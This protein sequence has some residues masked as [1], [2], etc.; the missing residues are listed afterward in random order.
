MPSVQ[1]WPLL[2]MDGGSDVTVVE[3]EFAHEQ[4][5]VDRAYGLLERGLADAE[6]N[7]EGHGGVHRAT[8][9]AMKRALDILRESRGTGQLIFGRV[10]D[11]DG[12]RYI[13]RRRVYDED[14]DLVVIG[15]HAPAAQVYYEA[16]AQDP[17]GLLLKRTFVEENRRLQRVIDEFVVRSAGGAAGGGAMTGAGMSDA[18][19]GEL[20]RSRDGA[21]RE[22]V[23]TIQAEQFRIIRADRDCVLVV[24]GGPGTGKTVVGLHRAAWL[25]FNHQQLRRQGILVV[26]PSSALLSYIAGVLPSL[27]ASDVSQTDLTSLYAGEARPV[28]ADDVETARVKG[29]AQ[30]AQMLRRALDARTGWTGADLELSLG[31]ARIRVPGE[32]IDELVATARRRVLPHNEAR[33]V[34]RQS[35]SALAFRHYSSAQQEAARPVVAN[36]GTVRR[37]TTFTNA[38]DRMWPTFTPED[39]L[40]T[41]YGTQSWL[42]E[43]AEGALTADERAR[44]FRTPQLSIA[45]E[46]WTETDLFCLDELSAMLN[47]ETV[48][49]GHIVVDEAQDLSPMQARALARRCPTGSFTIL[50]DLAQATGAWVRDRWEELTEHLGTSTTA[51]V[52]TL[53]V[54]YRLPQP[55]LELA[56]R[57]L[58]LISPGLR[59]P[60]SLR[61]GRTAPRVDKVSTG[62]LLQRAHLA[63]REAVEASLTTAIIVADERYDDALA[64]A[65]ESGVEVGD[66]RDGD[67]SKD[68]TLVAGSTAKGLEFDA[69]VLVAPEEIVASGPQG[70]RMLYVAMTRCTQELHVLH[71]APLPEGL[72]HLEV[73]ETPA[74][75]PTPRQPSALLAG[76]SPSVLPFEPTLVELVARLSIEDKALVEQLMLR[77][78]AADER[79]RREQATLTRRGSR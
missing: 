71:A 41:L 77:L 2:A 3:A 44:L 48:S 29:S 64:E 63:A 16:T 76:G 61:S 26:A 68:V 79:A 54:G 74:A 28:A 62:S 37:L 6:R 38:L 72:D 24:Q 58:P 46:P 20:E 78:L 70:R 55:V 30:M 27:D 75:I 57:Q 66:G 40:R 43:A 47:G 10:D 50:G 35:L 69:V 25:A 18:L 51:R 33:D 19:L 36:E 22:V 52:E 1:Q 5:Y 4:A 73:I 53:S 21:M 56:A 15:W 7:I 32:Q 49:Y 14:K 45:D 12:P 31:A 13:G 17:Q 34:L 60:R 23:A 8:A 65:L 67:F 39:F 42:I 59:A 11:E 9:H